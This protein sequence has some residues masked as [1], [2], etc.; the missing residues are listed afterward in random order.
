MI[1]PDGTPYFSKL[2]EVIDSGERLKLSRFHV[3]KRETPL[4]SVFLLL[5]CVASKVDLFQASIDPDGT[6][7]FSKLGK[8]ID[9]GERLKL[10]RFHVRKRE[11]PL[12]SVFLL[13]RCVASKV[14]LFQ[15]S[16]RPDFFRCIIKHDY[17]LIKHNNPATEFL[18]KSYVVLDNE[19][20]LF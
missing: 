9:S 14:D 5:R 2:G 15:A 13:L 7:Y 8:V 19:N 18:N 11:T 3:R 6:P 16:I 10:S 12:V 4:V 20:G 17:A 1:D